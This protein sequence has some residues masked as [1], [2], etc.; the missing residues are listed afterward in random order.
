MNPETNLKQITDDSCA[1]TH[2]AARATALKRAQETTAQLRANGIPI[3]RVTPTERARRNPRSLRAAVN[4]KCWDCA[5]GG[6]DAGTRRT[7]A[8]CSVTHCPLHAV[9]PYQRRS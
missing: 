6:Q 7:I 2:L 3:E 8:E 1:A 9:R 5:G 4:A